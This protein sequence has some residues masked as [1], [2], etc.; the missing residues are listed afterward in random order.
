MEVP[1]WLYP[2]VRVV[3]SDEGLPFGLA[4]WRVDGLS[5]PQEGERPLIRKSPLLETP[6]VMRGE[7]QW[8]YLLLDTR[9][10]AGDVP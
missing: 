4:A 3:A 10:L 8:C 9:W 6:S 7:P 5:V 1:A 2:S